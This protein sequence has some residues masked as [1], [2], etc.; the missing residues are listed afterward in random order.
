LQ[1]E[2]QTLVR[3]PEKPQYSFPDDDLLVTLTDLYFEHV[4]LFSPLLHRPTLE[5]HLTEKFHLE[6]KSFGAVVLL[7]CAIGAKFSDDPRVFMDEYSTPLTRG[8]KWF[9]QVHQAEQF[10]LAPA[11]LYDVQACSLT[12]EFL[13]GAS[14]PGAA[15]T[16]VGVGMR[17]AQDVGAHR[18]RTFGQQPKSATSELWTRAWWCLVILDRVA[19]AVTGR[20]CISQ[21]YDFDVGLPTDCDDEYW[22]HPDPK[23]AWKQP[24]GK[25]SKMSFFISFIGQSQILASTLDFLVRA[26]IFFNL[27]N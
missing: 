23:Q 11:S 5:K 1:W 22:D 24:E 19:S 20:P 8:W 21:E 9:N 18:W 15:W 17:L 25:P 7:V 12:A 2:Q 16:I 14:T 27:L 4:N 3:K 6:N 26:I 13:R 10:P